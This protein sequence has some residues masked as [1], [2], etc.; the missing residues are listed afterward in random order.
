MLVLSLKNIALSFGHH[1]LLDGVN[2]D[3]VKGQRLCLIGRNGAGK[4]SFLKIVANEIHPDSGER[5]VHNHAV[6]ASL[7]QEVPIG[8]HG[9]IFSIVMQGFGTLGKT[10][11]DYN[12]LIAQTEFN[13]ADMDKMAQLQKEIDHHHG[14]DKLQEVNKVLSK[15]NLDGDMDFDSLSGGMKRRVLLAQALV[16]SPDLLLLDE[17]TNHLDIESIQWLEEFL[18][19]FRGAI[20]FITHDRSFLQNV[21]N[22][23][24][25]LDRGRLI[26]FKGDY[27]NF[28]IQKEA[29]LEAEAQQNALFDKK[30]AQEEVWIRQGVKARRT[31]NEGRVRALEAMRNER[32][33]RRVQQGKVSAEVSVGQRSGRVV[34]RAENIHY[35]YDEQVLIPNLSVEIQRGDKVA[36]LGPNGCGKST[37]LGLLLKRLTPIQGTVEHGTNIEIAYFDQLRNQLNENKSVIDNVNDG[38]DFVEVNGQKIHAISYLQ[39][40][41][42]AA[43]R[44]RSPVSSL[45]GGEKNRLLLAKLFAK[46]SNLLILD[47]PTND[48]DIE[49]LEVLENLVIEYPGTILL[50][51]HDR[52]FINNV[53]TSS[54]V[55]ENRT[56]N[57]YIGG[58][59]DWLRQRDQVTEVTTIPNVRIDNTDH[60]RVAKKSKEAKVKLSFNQKQQLEK[61][62]LEIETLENELTN[63][64]SDLA[65]PDFYTQEKHIITITQ[66]RHSELQTLIEK[67]YSEW[68]QLSALAETL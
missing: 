26:S 68:E 29:L 7:K 30:L 19:Q 51:S 46:P 39:R 21:A 61:L 67:K 17:P 52:A 37:L 32:A 57:E 8:T 10:L 36:I 40:F 48:L 2:L 22:E 65:S 64:E 16:C 43:E 11:L 33:Q 41:L 59:D 15:L 60:N 3:I 6:I 44:L 63:I 56:I 50:V 53:A 49:T 4:S 42:F 12:H 55:F 25:E 38:S 14:W 35:K 62:P 66:Q 20:L 31:R 58:Y 54:L 9:S 45:S 47:E 1:K 24:V 13:D 23:I 28:L 34:I 5:I 18:P 27:Q